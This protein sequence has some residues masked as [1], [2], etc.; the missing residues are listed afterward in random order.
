MENIEIKLY[1]SSRDGGCDWLETI[2]PE[3]VYNNAINFH[4]FFC[5]EKGVKVYKPTKP[6]LDKMK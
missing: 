6:R 4:P 3:A 1:G 2:G 5:K